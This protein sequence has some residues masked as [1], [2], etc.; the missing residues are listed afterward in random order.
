MYSVGERAKTANK[1]VFLKG[2]AH[3]DKKE[4][5][6]LLIGN[7]EWSSCKVIYEEVLPNI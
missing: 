3:T 5:Q 7:S 6:I 4:K 2:G 1:A